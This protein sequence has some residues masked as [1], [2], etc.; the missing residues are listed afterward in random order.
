MPLLAG[1]AAL[2]V[3][4][5]ALGAKT[6]VPPGDSDEER[7]AWV[8]ANVVAD[9]WIHLSWGRESVSYTA[10]DGIIPME[11]GH[12]RLWIRSELYSPELHNGAAYR[13]SMELVQFDCADARY[14]LLAMDTYQF[15]NLQGAKSDYNIQ[16]TEWVYPRPGT[17][18]AA[19][20]SA[21]CDAKA[22]VD[23]DPD[24]ASIGVWREGPN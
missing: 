19:E 5:V 17:V 22:N 8:R 24:G 10:E 20:L 3:V 7:L 15:N 13:S 14:K 6:P 21:I 4:I 2:A 23:A 9:G 11:N 16:S 18:G 1:I 12:I